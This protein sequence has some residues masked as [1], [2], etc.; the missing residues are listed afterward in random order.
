MNRLKVA[1]HNSVLSFLGL[2]L[3]LGTPV[4]MAQDW[5][6]VSPKQPRANPP[7][8]APALPT[9]APAVPPGDREIVSA[10]KGLL[11]TPN[12][13]GVKRTGLDLHGIAAPGLD[14]LDDPA[15]RAAMQPNLGK[16]LTF[17]R[18]N[19]IIRSTVLWYREHDRPLVDVVVPE[20]DVT[21]GT[22]QIV[23]IEFRVGALAA[24]G[25]QWFSDSLLLSRLRVRSGDR[26]SSSAMLEDIEWLNR[27]PFRHTDLV[28]QRGEQPG[29][30][31]IALRTIDRF[32]VRVF[33]G[34][35]NTGTASTGRDRL[36][37]GFNWGNAFW[38][39]QQISYQLSASPDLFDRELRGPGGAPRS[40]IHAGSWSIPLPWRHT[41]SIFGSH[42]VTHPDLGQDFNQ[43]GRSSQLS[44][45]YVAPLGNLGLGNL[46]VIRHELQ[47][48][49]D[50]KRSNSNLEFGGDSVFRNSTDIAQAMLGY[51][52]TLPDDLGTTAL[53]ASVFHS[54]GGIGERNRDAVFAG[55]RAGADSHYTYARFGL[56]RM[57]RL[58]QDLSWVVR[59]QGQLSSANLLS[60]EQLSLGG[61]GSV[62]GYAESEVLGD[63][64]VLLSTEL[65][66]PETS[67]ARLFGEREL[68]DSLQGLV[69]LDSGVAAQRFRQVGDD[70]HTVV[71]SVGPGLRYNLPPYFSLKADWG[72]QLR[73]ANAGENRVARPHIGLTVSY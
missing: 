61:N 72:F 52:A 41:V 62:R 40:I 44:A 65:R 53:S 25:N 67:L 34:Y 68:G 16:P 32:P 73:H 70:R 30:T 63:R 13:A 47:G 39:D 46:G 1:L 11:F 14:L 60:S 49:V 69:F 24:E 21:D 33:G 2:I 55:S 15:F 71:L 20:Q 29:A 22:V 27:N 7:T 45:R 28:Y 66:S 37:A 3:S 43:T 12:P 31:D 57:T 59:L 38:S 5:G 58:P 56:D 35:E 4:A 10:L 9:P 51:S 50:W 6:R 23:V 17:D 8:E 18:L 42:S 64:G 19:A 36:F 48:G 54:P 26:V